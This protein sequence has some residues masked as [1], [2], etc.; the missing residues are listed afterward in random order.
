MNL[1]PNGLPVDFL[2]R[3]WLLIPSLEEAAIAAG[4]RSGADVVVF[5]LASISAVRRPIAAETLVSYLAEQRTAGENTASSATFFLLPEMDDVTDHLLERLMPARPEGILFPATDPRDVQEMDVLL[6]VHEAIN[7]LEDGAT[8]IA[9]L[10]GHAIQRD[11]A[12]LSRRLVALGW[13]AELYRGQTGA[14]RLFD[15]EGFLTDSFRMAR[16]SVLHAATAAGLE[17]IDAASG[18]W[19]P[20]RLTRDVAEGAADGFTGKFA[21]SPRQ[22]TAINHGFLPGEEEIAAARFDLQHGEPA[23]QLRHARALRTLQRAAL[24]EAR[25]DQA[26]GTGAL[27]RSISNTSPPSQ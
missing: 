24:P 11:Y 2:T 6:A 12:G 7:A 14:R 8:R 17:A 9:C 10:L 13:D 25:S 27:G 20:D 18:L 16:A 19:G 5:D 1:P 26:P 23:D 22:V 21:L 15:S 3:S 4:L